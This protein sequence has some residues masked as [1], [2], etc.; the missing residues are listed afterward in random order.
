MSGPEAK[1][2]T[3]GHLRLAV[4]VAVTALLVLAG[5]GSGDDDSEVSGEPIKIGAPID[6]TGPAG[7]AGADALAGAELAVAVLNDA[8]GLLGRPIELISRDNETKPEVA[9]EEARRLVEEDGVVALLAP[10]SS[11]AA[12]AVSTSV[13][14]PLQVPLFTHS[15]N[16]DALTIGEFHKYIFALGPSA[17][18]EAK[19]Q[20]RALAEE[21]HTKYALIGADYEGGHANVN[22]FKRYL[23]EFKPEVEYSLELYPPLG[24]TDFTS[25]IN[26]LIADEPDF[27][28]S[29]LFGADLVAFTKQGNAVGLF[30]RVEFSSLYDSTTLRA[31]GDDAPEGVR[32]YGRAPFYA[33]GTPEVA[34]MIEAFHEETG[35][36][37]SDFAIMGYDAVWA[38]AQGVEAA[39]STEADEVVAA[40]E[41]STVET[42]RGSVTLREIDH[43]ADVPE[44]YGTITHDSEYGFPIWADPQ[45]I[46]GADILLSEDEVVA[47][48]E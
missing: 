1:Q 15:S 32:A 48:R 18:M 38:W 13:A 9:V 19:A 22:A 7:A 41:G 14:K 17:L 30:D 29:V 10:A 40:L 26:R 46:P 3:M 11:G 24:E 25:H 37:P 45:E 33:V 2:G 8:G 47:L 20:A 34:T 12:L 35:D 4:G 6:L 28:Y 23:T 42:L 39:G 31:L 44:Y 27:V 21:Q 43:Q 5:C 16:T 36:Y